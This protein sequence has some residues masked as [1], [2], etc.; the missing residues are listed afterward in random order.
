[1]TELDAHKG[2]L[3]VNYNGAK[4]DQRMP[5]QDFETICDKTFY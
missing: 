1:M 4:K 2:L 3:E 5:F